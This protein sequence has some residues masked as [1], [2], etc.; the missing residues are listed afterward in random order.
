MQSSKLLP[1]KCDPAAP[2]WR[3]SQAV[4]I[5]NLLLDVFLEEDTYFSVL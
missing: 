1:W 5:G 4:E 2:S 3:C